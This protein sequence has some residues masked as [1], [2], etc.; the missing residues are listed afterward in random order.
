[1]KKEQILQLIEAAI[2]EGKDT[3][4]ITEVP[5]KEALEMCEEPEEV[6]NKETKEDKKY[7]FT[8][9]TVAHYGRTLHRIRRI[10]DGL[11]GGFIEKEDNLS[12]EGDC[13]VFG[14]ARVFG[15]AWVGWDAKVS[16]NAKV[17]G[18]AQ[19]YGNAEV[20]GN[21]EVCDNAEVLENAKVYGNAWVCSSAGVFG[22]A[23][24]YG[25]AG[26]HGNVWVHGKAQVY[27]RAEVYGDATV[28]GEAAISEGIIPS[29]IH[30]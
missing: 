2:L 9:E 13:F 16:G 5:F 18:D 10:E 12:H 19:V 30:R 29:G 17:F 14:N 8:G 22:N 27:G 21:A 23:K 20:S 11:V 7:E 28:R 25:N 4:N 15:R 1:M 6:N 26:I 3:I 24:V